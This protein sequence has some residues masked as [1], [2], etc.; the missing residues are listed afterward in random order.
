M[1]A[2]LRG[3]YRFGSKMLKGVKALAINFVIT[4]VMLSIVSAID[5]HGFGGWLG[6]ALVAGSLLAGVSAHVIYMRQEHWV[7]KLAVSA[8]SVLVILVAFMLSLLSLLISP[9]F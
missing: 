3:Q 1:T 6:F 9:E 2:A 5:P 8:F 4:L 7:F